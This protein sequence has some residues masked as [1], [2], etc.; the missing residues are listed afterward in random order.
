MAPETIRT[1]AATRHVKEFS[2]FNEPAYV[3][4]PGETLRVETLCSAGG[5]IKRSVTARSND[6]L[7]DKAGWQR[8]MPMTGPIYVEGAEPGDAL[9]I[10]LAAIEVDDFGWTDVQIGRGPAGN[11]IEEAEVRRF[12]IRNGAVDFGF[13]VTLPLAPMIGA[14]GTAPAERALGAGIPEAHGGNMD[15]TLIKPTSTLYLPVNVPGALLGLGDLHAAMGDGEVG[16]A[17]VEVGGTV[18]L[19]LGLVK[20]ATLPLPL[21]DTRTIVAAIVSAQE[22]ADAARGAVQAMVTWIVRATALG[23]N[24]ATMLVSLAGDLRICQIVDPLMT[25]R[26]EMPKRVLAE[27]GIQLPAV[28]P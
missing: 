6:E 17:G 14:I 2:P 16:T 18:T 7:R 20:R 9:G 23:V 21:V 26:M 12:P 19:K 4:S 15:C 25:C 1:L 3:V 22:L 8:G 5:S 28:G 10:Y 24:D 11:L 13:G 27:I